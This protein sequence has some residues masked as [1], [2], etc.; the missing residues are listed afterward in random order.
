MNQEQD[1]LQESLLP[2]N[3]NIQQAKQNIQQRGQSFTPGFDD[4]NR[5]NF[6]PSINMND[7][8]VAAQVAAQKKRDEESARQQRIENFKQ[9]SRN[10]IY[11]SFNTVNNLIKGHS[12]PNFTESHQQLLLISIEN[13]V[14][15]ILDENRLQID[16]RILLE[17]MNEM[18]GY[19]KQEYATNV[20]R[21]NLVN[22]DKVGY[23]SETGTVM[24]NPE[25]LYNILAKWVS[26]HKMHYQENDQMVL[27]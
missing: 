11:K 5:P 2:M 18:L 26:E 21:Y 15:E 13:K 7:P 27:S 4:P 25:Y 6:N 12:H 8:M 1:I 9:Y 20:Q 3:F 17:V 16:N 10:I 14:R 24:L 19:I 22:T 23:N